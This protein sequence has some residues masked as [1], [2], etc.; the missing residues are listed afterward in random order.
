[1]NVFPFDPSHDSR[2][3][4]APRPAACAGPALVLSQKQQQTPHSA[5]PPDTTWLLIRP[6][7]STTARSL[8]VVPCPSPHRTA[9]HR[10]MRARLVP[11][12]GAARS[13]AVR[14]SRPSPSR[15]SLTL[16]WP[17]GLHVPGASGLPRSSQGHPWTRPVLV[18]LAR[19]GSPRR[20]ESTGPGLP[21]PYVA[22]VCFKRFRRFRCMLQF[23]SF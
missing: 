6:P 2:P 16:P 19:C 22:Y 17:L 23:F 15:A 18:V 20:R 8:A 10:R 9:P 14:P 5:H 13:L 3:N 1:L 11:I 12:I 21:L 4:A 7:P